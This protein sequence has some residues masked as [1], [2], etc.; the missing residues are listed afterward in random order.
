VVAVDVLRA[1]VR[2]VLNAGCRCDR[3]FEAA[4]A[5]PELVRDLHTSIAAGRDVAE[6][7]DLAVLLHIRGTE[8]W[9]KMVGAPPDLRSQAATL[10][11]QTAH[12][13]DSPTTLGIATVGN[14]FW[15]GFGPFCVGL[16][17]MAEALEVGDHERAVA[18]A[19]GL[20][21]EVHPSRS[22]Q[23]AY[24][25]DYSRALVQV[26][27][28][29][30]DAVLAFHRAETISPVHLHRNPLARDALATLV[31]RSRQDAVGRELWGMAYRTG[32]PA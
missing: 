22:R 20:H 15:I 14:A 24:W 13:R 10:A 9:L 21:P 27:G 5:L 1:R 23:S 31:T 17:R 8:A 7:L 28:R 26:R 11:Q 18:T 16:W 4:A 30:D 25:L 6:L 29:H 2:A 3:Q 12:D 32:L 19:E